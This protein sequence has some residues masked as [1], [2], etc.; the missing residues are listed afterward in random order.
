MPYC[1]LNLLKLGRCLSKG[2]V[3]TY[4]ATHYFSMLKKFSFLAPAL[5]LAAC[6]SS[7]HSGSSSHLPGTWQAQPVVVDG[8][9]NEWPSPYPSYDA[10]A[11]IGYAMSNDSNNL[12]L[13]IET[14]DEMTQMKILKAGMTLWIDTSGG[15]NQNMAIN[16]P[17]P[18]NNEPLDLTKSGKRRD[19]GTDTDP[20]YGEN[21][22]GTIKGLSPKIQRAL[23]EA[24]QMT[25]DGFS[26]C[27]GG[28][29]I[30]QENNCGIQVIVSM[31]EYKE[32]IYE[33]AIPFKSL[34]GRSINKR[35]LGRH[36]SVCFAIKGFKAPSSNNNVSDANRSNHGASGMGGGGMGGGGMRGGGMH[37]AGTN[38][39]RQHLYESTKTWKQ[40]G[41]AF[42]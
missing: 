38:N 12:Y 39:P 9:N 20:A 2:S 16:F 5:L 22:T 30:K 18:N 37:S 36:I 32:L 17:L 13:T 19:Q 8:N 40:F 3:F 34:Y 4:F 35:D 28:F 15:K 24:R 25:I 26:A 10:K 27:N 31:D 29:M 14:G 33:A 7:K 11:M 23:D 41:L 21:I 42:Q 6:S 1:S